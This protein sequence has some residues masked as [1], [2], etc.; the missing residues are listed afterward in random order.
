[1]ASF[2]PIPQKQLELAADI[3][4]GNIRCVGVDSLVTDPTE[5]M[6]YM[7]SLTSAIKTSV[8]TPAL[9]ASNAIVSCTSFVFASGT[10]PYNRIVFYFTTGNPATDRIWLCLDHGRTSNLT[11]TAGQIAGK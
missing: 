10:G 1:M 2:W 6:Q 8:H 11:V 4:T 5:T 3:A 7:S 9:S